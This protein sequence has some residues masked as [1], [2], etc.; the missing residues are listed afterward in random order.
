MKARGE[1]MT[2]RVAMGP[3]AVAEVTIAVRGEPRVAGPHEPDTLRVP[4]IIEW[5]RIIG[6]LARLE[7]TS[8]TVDEVPRGAP[9]R[10]E[11]PADAGAAGKVVRIAGTAEEA[12]GI[13]AGE[14]G[15]EF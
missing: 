9:A 5:I 8:V 6:R 1:I 7:I 2:S 10:A 15:K 12:L 13:I 4:T 14:G 3:G 11:A